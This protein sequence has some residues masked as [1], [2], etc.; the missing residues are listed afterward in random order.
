MGDNKYSERLSVGLTIEQ[1]RRLDE[2]VR[3]RAR[4]GGVTVSKADL[5][6]AAIEFYFL[7]QDDLPGS[8]KAIANAIEGKVA[9]LYARVNDMDVRLTRLLN[10]I[11]ERLR[12]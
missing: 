7:H 6:R 4:K 2:L 11:E 3:V 12:R 8:R 10:F 5:I 9:E 1:V